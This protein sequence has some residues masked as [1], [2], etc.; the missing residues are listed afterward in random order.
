MNEKRG[1]GYLFTG[2]VI[3]L[4]IGFVIARV[5]F[6]VAYV[7]TLPAMLDEV[8][9]DRYRSMIAIA[10]Q[11]NNDLPRARARLNLLEDDYPV[12]ALLDQA[13]RMTQNDEPGQTITALKILAADLE[14]ENFEPTEE[15]SS[16][17]KTEVPQTQIAVAPTAT[18]GLEDAIHT[19]TAS[20]TPSPTPVF[21]FTPRPTLTP[22]V[23]FDVPFVLRQKQEVCD[24]SLPDGLLQILV[25]DEDG[26]PLP[27]ARIYVMWNG[28]EE[29]FFT[30]LYP[31]VSP[32]YADFEMVSGEQYQVRV[33]TDS[34]LVDYLV[35]PMCEG[36]ASEE[37]NGGWL[38][39]FSPLRQSAVFTIIV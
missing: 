2:L 19:P 21:T 15:L 30:G 39:R 35:V 27:G 12:G 34:D 23:S 18:L 31:Q 10:Y 25:E 29:S 24:T 4:I 6:P 7:D 38:L 11:V 5:F 3:G 16:I 32:G 26:E 14:G 20:P 1:P 33:G 22:L 8:S 37:Y 36:D 9:K 13:R 28:G 17:T